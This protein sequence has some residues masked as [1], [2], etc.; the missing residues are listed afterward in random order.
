MKNTLRI[1][2]IYSSK[3]SLKESLLI[4]TETH[5]FLRQKEMDLSTRSIAG[6]RI[7]MVGG[8]KE[9]SSS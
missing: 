4:T 2:T 1:L 6:R 5:S 3:I 8:R 9:S 7:K